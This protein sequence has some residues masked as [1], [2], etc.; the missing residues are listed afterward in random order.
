LVALS[1]SITLYEYGRAVWARHNATGE[2]LPIALWRLAGRNRRRYGGYV[3]HLGVVMMALG[4]IGIEMFQEQTQGTILPGQTITLSDYTV[5]LK[6]LDVFD[7][8]DGTNMN[9]GRAVLDITK[10]GQYLGELHPRRDYYYESQQPMTIP[11]VRSNLEDD[12]YI[13]L[14]D[15]QLEG[16][17]G[18]TLKVFHNPLVMWM[19]LGALVFILGT[20]IAAWPDKDP[21]LERVR[22]PI[23]AEGSRV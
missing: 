21:E 16:A 23:R 9:I 14:V 20:S 11:G 15:W 7:T 4:V 22:M 18:V 1:G 13:I 2:N 8:Q 19:W 6:K 5:T 10:G 17:G 12:L 3:I